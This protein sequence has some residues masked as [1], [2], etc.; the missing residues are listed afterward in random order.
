MARLQSTKKEEGFA[1]V[2][3]LI[4][5]AIIA[6]LLIGFE[7]LISQAIKMNRVNRTEL[8]A[9]LY[10]QEAIEIAKDLELSDWDTLTGS[11]CTSSD[12]CYPVDSGGAWTLSNGLESLDSGSYVRELYVEDVCRDDSGF[13]NN[14][15]DCPGSFNDPNTKKVVAT[16]QWDD[17]FRSRNLSLEAYV[18]KYEE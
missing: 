11:S 9:S 1:I 8:K 3:T 7:V 13:P 4:S 17:S 10:L 2:E 16:V 14:I 18:Y 6:L 12:V 5:I 15:V